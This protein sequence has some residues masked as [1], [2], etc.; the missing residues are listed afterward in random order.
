M[1]RPRLARGEIPMTGPDQERCL[2]LPVEVDGRELRVTAVSMGN[3]HAVAFVDE[4]GAAL[5]ALAERHGRVVETHPWFPHRTNVEL[6]RAASPTEI[7]VVVWERGCGI[8]LA[9]GT[10]ACATAV[11]ACLTGRAEPGR[12]LTVRLL[13]GPLAVTVARDY[14]GVTMRGPATLVFAAQ[15]DLAAL[16]ARA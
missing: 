8:T 9:C 11:A 10:G 5:R 12:E 16:L 2:E 3:P 4:R 7:E 15:I 14:T 1:G 6:A 13:G